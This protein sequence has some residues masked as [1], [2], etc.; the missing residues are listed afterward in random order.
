MTQGSNLDSRRKRLRFRAWRRGIKEMDYIMGSFLDRHHE[1][2]TEAEVDELERLFDVP[3]QQAFAW[4][5]GVD[6]VPPEYDT[7]LF[8][9]IRRARP[10]KR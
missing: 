1:T 5:T 7:P 10:M 8:A 6:P 3:D 2:L 9:R 4:V